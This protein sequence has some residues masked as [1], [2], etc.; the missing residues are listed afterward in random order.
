MKPQS[1]ILL[2]EDDSALA[3]GLVSVLSAER[4]DV[5]HA[6]RGDEGLRLGETGEFDCVL[7][8]LRLPGLGGL[9]LIR[10]LHAAR[11]RLPIV[12]MTAHGTTETAIEATKLGAF[13]YLLKP[14]EMEELIDLVAKAVSSGRQ[15]AEVVELGASRPG[16]ESIVGRGRAMQ[17]IYKELGR[18][19]AQPVSV[20]IRGE[21]GTG[22]ELIARALF[23]HSNRSSAP[24]IAVNC[25]AI[26]ETL[27]ESELFGH[28]RGAFTGAVER[29]IGRFEQAHGGTLFLDEIGEMGASTQAKLLRVLQERVIQRVG[30]RDIIPVDV[31]IIAATHVA[32]EEAIASKLFREDLFYRLNQVTIALPALRERI[33]DLS[34]LVQHFLS[35][36]APALGISSPA[37]LPEAL[38]VLRQHSWPGNVRELENAIR[39]A[40]LRARNYP[41]TAAIVRDVLAGAGTASRDRRG[42]SE[43]I[44]SEL[45][46]A[47]AADDG[48]ASRR[49]LE[50]VERELYGQAI[51]LASGNQARAARWLGVSRVTFR[52]K[53]RQFG[54]KAPGEAEGGAG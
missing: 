5:T 51:A 40:L 11:P 7:T 37:L 3:G 9:D 27:L 23:Q 20:L 1:R 46:A 42:L 6:S 49:V 29:R 26:P 53:L 41:I 32:L 14:F 2:I 4:H 35:L 30:G 39:L 43:L 48:D 12:L 33:E 22:K 16:R 8:D 34:E 21:T 15:A 28:E 18:V 52:E 44:A 24:F 54:L 36:H 13:D 10:R 50:M 31:R 19:A 47:Q 25:A 17:A 45:A 38:D